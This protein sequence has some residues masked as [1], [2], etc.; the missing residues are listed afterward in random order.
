VAR[1]LVNEGFDVTGV[2][3]SLVQIDRAKRLV[4]AACFICADMASLKFPPGRFDA[5]VSFYAIIHVPL[6][7]QQPLLSSMRHWLRPGGRL[8]ATVGNTSW[9]G[10]EQDWLDVP[11]ATMIWSHAD[12]ATY[13][14]WLAENGF[15][16]R[17]IAAV[18]LPTIAAAAD[19]KNLAAFRTSTDLP[20]KRADG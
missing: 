2:D 16:V 8:M 6:E 10:V 4:A 20:A 1:R 12:S 17:W 15:T 13:E 5:I 7:E 3:I 11:G 14:K 19:I 9:S 18:T